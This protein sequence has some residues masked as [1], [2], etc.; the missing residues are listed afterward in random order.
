[1]CDLLKFS[2]SPL[3]ADTDRNFA[4]FVAGFIKDQ[5]TSLKEVNDRCFSTVVYC[6]YKFDSLRGVDYNS[7]WYVSLILCSFLI[8]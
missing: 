2:L 1:M 7:V 8:Y 3:F 5:Y 4:I 6:K